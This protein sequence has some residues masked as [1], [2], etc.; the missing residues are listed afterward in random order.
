VEPFLRVT[1]LNVYVPYIVVSFESRIKSWARSERDIV[2][3]NNR[4]LNIEP[5]NN[6]LLKIN[7]SQVQE[8][9]PI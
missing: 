1:L 6:Y 4:N 7:Y 3:N 8:R 9:Y 2:K 5:P